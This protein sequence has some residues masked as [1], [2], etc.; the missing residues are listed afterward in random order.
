MIGEFFYLHKNG[1]LTNPKALLK[2][3]GHAVCFGRLPLVVS[4]TNRLHLSD[5]PTLKR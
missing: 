2:C 1:G 4:L 3:H 5:I